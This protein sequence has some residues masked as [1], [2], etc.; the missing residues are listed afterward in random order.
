ME[1]D[2][3]ENETVKPKVTKGTSGTPTTRAGRRAKAGQKTVTKGGGGKKARA[4][5]TYGVEGKKV[6]IL[7]SPDK[8]KLWGDL[9][10]I[11]E[12]QIGALKEKI[13]AGED[14]DPKDMNK[15]DSCYGGMKKLLE[16]EAIL[17]SD[18]ISSMTTEEL[19]R[20]CK[21]S[22]RESK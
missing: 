19:K 21:K 12:S 10:A 22:L 17:K 15:L 5:G 20:M 6:K 11:T 18:A 1:I 7:Q 3:T 4:S 13:E 8:H 2:A 14:L 16:I 9:F